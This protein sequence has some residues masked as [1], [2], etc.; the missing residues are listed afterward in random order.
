M[1]ITHL[2]NERTKRNG[3]SK[4]EKVRFSR[5]IF[6]VHEVCL[7]HAYRQYTKYV[8]HSFT[9]VLLRL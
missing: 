4:G 1:E 5:T 8:V 7:T 9:S 6:R 2:K 3:E